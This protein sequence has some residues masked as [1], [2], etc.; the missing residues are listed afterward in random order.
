MPGTRR[1][2]ATVS[3]V[4][5]AAV[6]LASGCAAGEQSGAREPAAKATPSAS[7]PTPTV[8][9]TA[10]PKTATKP[11]PE[12]FGPEPGY[13][14][15]NFSNPTTFTN[16][17]LP[18]KP[19]MQYVYD[20]SSIEDGERLAHRVISTVTD[21]T[22]EIDGVRNRVVWD[23]DYSD[24][25]LVEAELAFFAQANDGSVWHFGEHSEEYEEGKFVAAS[26]WIH[27][28]KGAQAGITITADPKPGDPSH[29]QG[30][31]PEVD[32]TDRSRVYRVNQRTCVPAGC[33]SGVLV[34]A[35]YSKEEPNAYQLKYYAPGVGNVRV[36]YAG[37]DP[38]KETLQLTRIRKLSAREMA[39]VR[40]EARKLEAHGVKVSKTVYG[41][42]APMQSL[43]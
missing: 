27:G 2:F 28:L 22:K 7:S 37:M 43:S 31:G 3:A 17:W 26:P 16:K 34:T 6:L 24:G 13:D 4:M 11:G 1:R 9:S 8:Q 15:A 21:L 23:L 42:T 39:R 25:E 5:A 20:G 36:G 30:W 18:L 35:E 19:G 38:T 41:R 14:R 29:A 33:Y 10:V 32:W 40:A 12:T